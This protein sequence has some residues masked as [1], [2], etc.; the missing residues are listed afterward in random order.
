MRRTQVEIKA[1]EVLYGV[2]EMDGRW[3]GHKKCEYCG[4]RVDQTSLQKFTLHRNIRRTK[5]CSSCA[6]SGESNG[7]H[8]RKHTDA[9]K[10]TVSNSRKGKAMGDQN[11][12]ANPE[13]R[14]RARDGNQARW[15]SGEL[16][17]LREF[18]RQNLKKTI[19]DGK[20]FIG[21]ESKKE[22]LLKDILE[23]QGF[24]V[25][26]QLRI[27]PFRYDLFIESRNTIVEFNGNYWHCNPEK[28]SSDYFNKKKSMYAHEIWAR[29]AARKSAAEAAGYKLI[30]VWE[31]DFDRNKTYLQKLINEI[32]N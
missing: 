12:M 15:D 27:E 25:T 16:E 23:Q 1:E 10:S 6:N 28:Y 26:T 13:Y 24:E 2:H 19:A 17:Y 8:G 3:Y 22:K 20:L 9:T 29:D 5:R 31:S 11:P 7:F 14:K 21:S 30:C 4:K 32:N 18:Y